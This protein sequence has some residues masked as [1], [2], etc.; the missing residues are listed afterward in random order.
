M[1]I[2]VLAAALAVSMA[3]TAQ[4][5]PLWLQ[6]PNADD[7]KK[8]YPRAALRNRDPAVVELVC[9]V[10]AESRLDDCKVKSEEPVGLGFGEAALK[11]APKF[12]MRKTVNGKPVAVGTEATVPIKFAAN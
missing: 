3:G 10:N 12:K 1:R 5:N 2:A 6:H 11:L 4:A 9:K 7:I 8:V